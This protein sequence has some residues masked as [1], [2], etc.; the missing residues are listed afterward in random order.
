MRYSLTESTLWFIFG[1][2]DSTISLILVFGFDTIFVG[3]DTI[4]RGVIYWG[5]EGFCG[6]FRN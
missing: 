5:G 1:R 3:N 4:F 6:V 2:K